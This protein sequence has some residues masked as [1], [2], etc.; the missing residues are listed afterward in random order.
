MQRGEESWNTQKDT[1][2]SDFKK[3]L[4]HPL[5]EITDNAFGYMYINAI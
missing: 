4:E 1:K 2:N 3:L 5:H